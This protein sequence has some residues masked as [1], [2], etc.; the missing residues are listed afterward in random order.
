MREISHVA[1]AGRQ[2]D[3]ASP[4]YS[5]FEV[6]REANPP[7]RRQWAG[8]RWRSEFQIADLRFHI[9]HLRFAICNPEGHAFASAGSP[10]GLQSVVVLAG[11]MN[12]P[13]QGS[14]ERLSSHLAVVIMTR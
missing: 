11:N 2:A 6:D 10:L 14:S 4:D 3:V 7:S 8:P 1:G 13:G 12:N 5:C 9:W